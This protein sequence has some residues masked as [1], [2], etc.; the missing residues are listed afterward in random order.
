MHGFSYV[1]TVDAWSFARVVR[2]HFGSDLH[3]LS[4]LILIFRFRLQLTVLEKRELHQDTQY[5]IRQ[6][7]TTYMYPL[8]IET[9]YIKYIITTKEIEQNLPHGLFTLTL[10]IQI[11]RGSLFYKRYFMQLVSADITISKKVVFCP[12]S[13]IG[14]RH[15]LL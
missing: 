13:E 5:S 1:W 11:L 2:C 8:K 3:F 4:L 14:L 7:I 10:R 12:I 6:K 15:P 9:F